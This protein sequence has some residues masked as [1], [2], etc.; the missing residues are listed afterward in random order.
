M[1]VGEHG[2]LIYAHEFIP[3]ESLRKTIQGVGA[4]VSVIHQAIPILTGAN[5]KMIKMADESLLVHAKDKLI[6]ALTVDD[7]NSNDNHRRLQT[8]VETFMS[9]YADILPF[10]T[11]NSSLEIF[12]DMTRI[13]QDSNF[14]S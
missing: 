1:V 2:R 7:G 12:E 6:F 10:L 13:I 9:K 3:N 4:L 11:E 8:F 14:F 5:I